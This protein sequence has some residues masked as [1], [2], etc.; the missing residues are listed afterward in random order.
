MDKIEAL[1]SH[2]SE[3]TAIFV[4][5]IALSDFAREH[6]LKLREAGDLLRTSMESCEPALHCYRSEFATRL[7]K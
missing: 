2:L 6:Q 3:M 7:S 5:P 1:L 4:D